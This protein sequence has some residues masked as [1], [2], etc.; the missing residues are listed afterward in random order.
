[1][2]LL[3]QISTFL[4]YIT[5]RVA[6]IFNHKALL[7]V[8]GRKNIFN[9]L[10]KQLSKNDDI[11]WFHCASL[12]EFEQGRPIIEKIKAEQ[13]S[14]KILITF[15][16]P[17]GYELQKNYENADYIF[18]LPIDSKKNAQRF[19]TIVNPKKVFFIKYEFWY[20][21]LSE[22]NKRKIPTYLISGI[23]RKDQLFFKWYGA[24]Y[25]KMLHYFTHFFV[26]NTASEQ[27]LKEYGIHNITLSGDNR[28]DRVYE[29][30]LTPTKLSIIE[31]FKQK[32][33]IIIAGSSWPIEEKAFC[34][35][36]NESNEDVKF[37]I[38]PHDI[39]KS[40][41]NEIE[42]LLTSSYLKYSDATL[43]NVTTVKTLII[44]NIGILA[45][46]YQYTDIAFVGG[47]Y[48]GSLHNILEPASFGNTILLGPKHTKFPEAQELIDKKGAFE[49]TNPDSLTQILQ[50]ITNNK[51]L[52]QHKNASKNYILAKKGATSIIWNHLF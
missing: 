24:W 16:S 45:N 6:S 40:H 29:N 42:N 4:Y 2:I 21:Y 1:M 34:K 39:K 13:P 7:W 33:Q 12:G 37:I 26:Q 41:I 35:Y 11:I 22:L 10:E 25:R 46:T 38:A 5:I 51:D 20:H 19:L 9:E 49:I 50:Q 52:L 14:T 32:K 43:N 30:S 8:N 27:L 3:Y 48:T 15:F 18:Y 17:S 23:F 36:I 31:A 44:D 28:F 47:G